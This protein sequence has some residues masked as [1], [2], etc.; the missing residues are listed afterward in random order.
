M[1]IRNAADGHGATITFA[2]FV[3]HII[4]LDGPSWAREALESSHL[5]TVD[6]KTFIPSDLADPGEISGE[7]EF[8]PQALPPILNAAG[9]LTIVWGNEEEDEFS[10]S[11]FMTSF[12]ASGAKS[13][14]IMK[15]SFTFKCSGAPTV[16]PG[17]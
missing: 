7:C 2:G 16:T 11:A 8:D 12:K 4:S 1:T 15:A 3:M 6:W 14:E 10:T 5:G 9:T 13:G 17:T